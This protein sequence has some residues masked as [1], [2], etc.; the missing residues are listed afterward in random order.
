MLKE[1][2][3][4]RASCSFHT[5]AKSRLV[6]APA[7]TSKKLSPVRTLKLSSSRRMSPVDLQEGR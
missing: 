7:F 1:D 6:I 5:G 4:R 2:S 3:F